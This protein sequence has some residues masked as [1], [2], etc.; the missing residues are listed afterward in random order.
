MVERRLEPKGGELTDREGDP[1]GIVEIS[2][3]HNHEDEKRNNSTTA[4]EYGTRARTKLLFLD[5]D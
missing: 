3:T 5:L 1:W 2:H 4:T